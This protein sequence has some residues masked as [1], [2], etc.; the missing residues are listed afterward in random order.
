M[1]RFLSQDKFSPSLISIRNG[2]SAITVLLLVLA[3]AGCTSPDIY[4]D[5]LYNPPVHWG[6]HVVQQ[7]DTLYGIAWRYGRDARELAD[8]NGIRA[9][10]T[11]TPG[12]VIRLDLRGNPN[13]GTTTT[14][15]QPPARPP[16]RA[17]AGTHS[18]SSPPQKAT[19]TP[20]RNKQL[21]R[22]DRNVANINW[23]WPFV[24]P[25]IA[26][27]STSGVINKGIDIA[28]EAGAPIRAAA[29]GEV[30]Y[31]GSGLLGYGELIIINHNEHYLSAYAHNRKILVKEGQRIAQGQQI[32]ELG[33]TG[34]NRTKLH[35]EIR[36]SGKP[37]D[38]MR[39]LPPR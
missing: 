25:V 22:D 6:R 12:Q 23:R 21:Q 11:I 8:A 20:K 7:G 18:R 35:F 1:A 33:A 14:S 36:K 32:A 3:V 31:A 16:Q 30:V 19:N 24:G 2:W 15:S 34:T 28:G 39:Y 38:P 27:F 26:T 17:Q 9:P 29:D 37:V 5:D 4:R 10:F 13:A